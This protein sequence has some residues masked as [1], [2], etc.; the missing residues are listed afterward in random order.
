[1]SNSNWEP[2]HGSIST[3][4]FNYDDIK[5]TI[6]YAEPIRASYGYM[7]IRFRF[8]VNDICPDNTI[9]YDKLK[10]LKTGDII[11]YLKVILFNKVEDKVGEYEYNNLIFDSFIDDILTVKTQNMIGSKKK[12]G[13]QYFRNKYN[14]RRQ[15]STPHYY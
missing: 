11:E 4:E 14:T 15:T 8:G 3:I 1:M 6:E 7:V 5:Y 10:T 9:A 2:I 13:K 12:K